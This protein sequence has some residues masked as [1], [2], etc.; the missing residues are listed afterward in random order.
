MTKNFFL[1]VII[2]LSFSS[3]NA[4]TFWTG[5]MITF[6]K[7]D[8]ADW[9]LPENQDRI[10]DNVWITRA[11]RKG[12]FNIKKESFYAGHADLGSSPVDTEWA[13]GS[14]ADGI[15]NLTFAS[16]AKTMD[17]DP[18]YAIGQLMVLHLKSDNIYIDITFNDWTIGI[19]GWGDGTGTVDP[20]KLSG[21]GG[22]SYE[23][24][25]PSLGT[26]DFQSSK[27][28]SIYPNPS[29]NFIE[30]SGFSNSKE[31]KIFDSIGN[32]VLNGN[33]SEGEKIEIKNLS[34]GLYF[35]NFDN[36]FTS[37]FMKN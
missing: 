30:I 25:T 15:E 29:Q 17:F 22:F 24:S 27:N 4:Q 13:F 10:T 34:N 20:E 3:I 35:I 28:I 5:P 23:R 2:F 9:K 31:Y 1:L 36:E 32:E 6:T 7:E 11:N 18:T 16:W 14:I 12:I 19:D 37:K 33:I 21:G 26:N 8:F